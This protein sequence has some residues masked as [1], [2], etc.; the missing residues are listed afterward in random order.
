MKFLYII[1]ILFIDGHSSNFDKLDKVLNPQ[2]ISIIENSILKEALKYK[3]FDDVTS[4]ALSFFASSKNKVYSGNK[5]NLYKRSIKLLELSSNNG[6]INA[7]MFL[8]MNFLK[9]KPIFSR[10]IAKNIILKNLNKE[11]KD[12]LKVSKNLITTFVSLTLDHFSTNIKEVNLAIEALQSLNKD[13]PQINLYL[14]FLF[15]SLDSDELADVYLNNACLF[16]KTKEIRLFC[17]SQ[18]LE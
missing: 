13:T 15:V 16:A 8:I 18:R 10:D 5:D 6:N 1:L 14:A 4:I 3:N 2:E 17:S 12:Y 11:N 7:S 9:T